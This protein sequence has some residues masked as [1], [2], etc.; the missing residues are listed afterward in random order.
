VTVTGFTT[1]SLPLAAVLPPSPAG[2]TLQVQPDLVE[3]TFTTQGSVATALT[4]PNSA[5]LVGVVLH[6]QLVLLQID[7]SA[8]FVQNTVSNAINLT[9]GAF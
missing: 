1:V 7:A 8:A 4:L 3:T 9:I 6:Q 2:C 5:S